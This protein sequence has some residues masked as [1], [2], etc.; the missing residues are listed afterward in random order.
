MEGNGWR[1]GGMEGSKVEIG[2]AEDSGVEGG[3][4][5]DGVWRLK[6]SGLRQ[7]GWRLR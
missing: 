3:G 7:M 5:E 4:M 1:V 6:G 2:G